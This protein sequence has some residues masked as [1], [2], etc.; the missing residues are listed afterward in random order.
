MHELARATN[1]YFSEVGELVARFFLGGTLVALFAVVGDLFTPKTFAGLFAAAPSVALATMLLTLHKEGAALVAVEARSMIV[2]AVAFTAYA[3][4]V[5]WVVHRRRTR[6]TAVAVAALVVWA[7][8]AAVG[9]ALF[10][11]PL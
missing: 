9:W 6:P 7:A 10:V 11:R 2:G 8:V 4:V 5:A 1:G 3:S